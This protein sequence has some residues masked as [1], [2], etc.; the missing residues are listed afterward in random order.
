MPPGGQKAEEGGS[1]HLASNLLN[2]LEQITSVSLGPLWSFGHLGVTTGQ[3]LS[4]KFSFGKGV[5]GCQ[6]PGLTPG[7]GQLAQ[8]AAAPGFLSG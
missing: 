4:K 6:D 2:I 3:C 8:A 5:S 1:V 7:V